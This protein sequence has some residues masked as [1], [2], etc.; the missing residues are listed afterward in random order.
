V[1]DAAWAGFLQ[2]VKT[3]TAF[4]P[5]QLSPSGRKKNEDM[6]P[7]MVR[8]PPQPPGAMTI[9]QVQQG[10]KDIG[11]FPGG[12]VD[13]I[14]GYRTRSAIRL[15]Q[16]Y[17]RTYGGKPD[18]T[19]DGRFGPRTQA[20]LERQ[21]ASGRKVEWPRRTGEHDAWLGFLERVKRQRQQSPGPVL[22]AVNAWP[23]PTTTRKV[24]DWD[25]QGANAIHL[26]GVRRR[27]PTKAFDDIFVL[28]IKGMVFKLHGTTEPGRPE[29]G[30]VP[31]YLVE[32]QHAY[33]F[34]WHQQQQLALRPDGFERG[35]GPLV[36]RATD[37]EAGDLARLAGRI[38]TESTINIHWGGARSIGAQINDWSAGC[39]VI[40]GRFY[41][42]PD[43]ELQDCGAFTAINND[44][45]D[46][47]GG[48][49][50]GAYS[51]VL[52]LV[53]ALSGDM[54]TNRVLYTLLNES[55]LGIDT[56]LK[57]DLDAVR[58]RIVAKG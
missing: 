35:V 25:F 7:G 1:T 33:R 9:S 22:S 51:F 45:V 8:L 43:G 52:D 29:A 47:A 37:E 26:V 55:D 15:F 44:A 6:L 21:L 20:E 27:S 2:L 36:I 4:D 53:T 34:S 14:C 41:V 38:E 46:P 23:R 30:K 12:K 48:K 31:P 10:L 50:R 58:A 39:Q 3:L 16:E 54:P 24:R 13:G 56:A 28:L 42:T 40:Q 18:F 11:I 17:V 32:G 49:T 57:A 5:S 19:P